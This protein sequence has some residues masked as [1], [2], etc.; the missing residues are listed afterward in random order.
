ML[1]D[2]DALPAA[3]EVF[4]NGAMKLWKSPPLRID[5]DKGRSIGVVTELSTFEDVDGRWLCASATAHDA[6]SWL[7]L[8]TPASITY[9]AYSR[10]SLGAAERV[11]GGLVTEVSVLS[12]GV[13]PEEPRAKVLVCEPYEAP[14]PSAPRGT[15]RRYGTGRVLAVGGVPLGMRPMTRSEQAKYR[16]L[17]VAGVPLE[18]LDEVLSREGVAS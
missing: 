7:Q 17:V 6:P 13:R 11:T 16:E 9:A 3:R 15:L 5:H 18:T 14:R 1:R 4:D 12:P 10:S 2:V 8:G